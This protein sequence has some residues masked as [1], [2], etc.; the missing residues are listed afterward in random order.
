MLLL[1]VLIRYPTITLLLLFAALGLRDGQRNTTSIIGALTAVSIAA[2]LLGTPHPDLVLP[3]IPRL[4]VRFLDVPSVVLIWWFGRSLFEDDF[5]LGI[6]EWGIMVVFSLP[7][8]YFRLFELGLVPNMPQV[9]LILVSAMSVLL[10][11]HL[12]YV[13][14]VG[15][16]DDVIESRRRLRFYFVVG[17]VVATILTV[18]GERIFYNDFPIEMNIFRSLTVL[19]LVL[20]GVFWLLK[21]QPEVL[22]FREVSVVETKPKIAARDQHLHANLLNHMSEQKAYQ[23]HGL[24][25]SDLAKDLNTPEHHLRSLINKGMGFRNFSGFLNHYRIQAVQNAMAQPANNRIPILTLALNEGFN[26]LAPFNRAFKVIVGCTPSEYKAN[27][28]DNS[29]TYAD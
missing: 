16:T 14:L 17:L 24:T 13:T 21:Y 19:P 25:I 11:L 9:M 8:S 12:I 23:R 3:D 10:M 28:I 2:L 22:A 27:I 6:I 5:S 4:I 15:R 1:D 18:V 7:V 20:F 26:S 29:V